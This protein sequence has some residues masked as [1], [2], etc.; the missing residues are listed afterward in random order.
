MFE[1][2]LVVTAAESAAAFEAPF[3]VSRGRQTLESPPIR[4]QEHEGLVLTVTILSLV[5]TAFSPTEN[6]SPVSR[7]RQML[8]SP[9]TTTL[10]ASEPL[11]TS[12]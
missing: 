3:P 2:P 5:L 4:R 7:D 12:T 8:E 11:Q 1:A 6:H 10:E 9:P